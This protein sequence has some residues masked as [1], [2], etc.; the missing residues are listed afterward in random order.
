MKSAV[1]LLAIAIAATGAVDPVARP[2]APIEILDTASL[3]R[4]LRRVT[5]PDGGSLQQALDAAR[6]GDWIE[7]QSG[8]TFTGPFRLRRFEGDGLSLIHI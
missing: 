7:L 1:V 3:P 4:A 6:P 5:V 2:Q 8:A